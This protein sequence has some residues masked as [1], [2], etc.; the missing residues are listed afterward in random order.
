MT[1]WRENGNILETHWMPA[2]QDFCESRKCESP[3]T[4][5][6]GGGAKLTYAVTLAGGR[7]WDYTQLLLFYSINKQVEKTKISKRNEWMKGKRTVVNKRIAKKSD[8]KEYQFSA[9]NWKRWQK[10][11]RWVNQ[12]VQL[13]KSQ[14]MMTNCWIE[15]K[16]MIINV[17][18]FLQSWSIIEKRQNEIMM[19]SA[20]TL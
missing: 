10:M 20:L 9:L 12:A 18:Q 5:Q 3:E 14:W 11:S 4:F 2:S 15:I 17:Q 19:Q 8:K 7:C 1:Q 16:V 13:N 6:L